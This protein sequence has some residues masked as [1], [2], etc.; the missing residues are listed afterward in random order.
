MLVI[1]LQTLNVK[2]I[3]SKT[4]KKITEN[5]R[6]GESLTTR[7]NLVFMYNL[8]S[9]V[10]S[11]LCQSSA[12]IINITLRQFHFIGGFAFSLIVS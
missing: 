10:P 6:F 9:V 8:S 11:D 12:I 7:G 1:L 5:F 3:S 2:E 4:Y